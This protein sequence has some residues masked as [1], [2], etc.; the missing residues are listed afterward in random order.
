VSREFVAKFRYLV[1]RV[2]SENFIYQEIKERANL[3]NVSYHS[4]QLYLLI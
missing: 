4:L 3:R 2:T 1:R